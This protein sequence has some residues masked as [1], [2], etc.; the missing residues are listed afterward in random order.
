MSLRGKEVFVKKPVEY[1]GTQKHYL[2]IFK[3]EC[4]V[5]EIS[6]TQPVFCFY[7]ISSVPNNFPFIQGHVKD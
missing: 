6:C 5:Y 1:F 2:E 4:I 7:C 3:N